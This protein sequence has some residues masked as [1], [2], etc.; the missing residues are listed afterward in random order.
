MSHLVQNDP[1][2]NAIALLIG[3]LALFDLLFFL[4]M[5]C[6]LRRDQKNSRP[7]Q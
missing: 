4:Y 1:L 7:K 3:A 5:F 2:F 6:R